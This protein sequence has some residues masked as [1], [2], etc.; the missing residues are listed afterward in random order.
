MTEVQVCST[1]GCTLHLFNTHAS[2][3]EL[4]YVCHLSRVSRVTNPNSWT[5]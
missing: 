2:A 5:I 3:S 1:A 4:K